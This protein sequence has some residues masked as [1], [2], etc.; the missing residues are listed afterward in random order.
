MAHSIYCLGHFFIK[1]VWPLK[2]NVYLCRMKNPT[3]IFNIKQ[4][5]QYNTVEVR[6]EDLVFLDFVKG[7]FK[8]PDS[9]YEVV[10]YIGTNKIIGFKKSKINT[11][12]YNMKDVLD[13]II[14]D[15]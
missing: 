12:F 4:I 13:I 6:F 3:L 15:N 11:R 9:P 8:P 2:K 1:K 5:R 10:R 7:D 14:V